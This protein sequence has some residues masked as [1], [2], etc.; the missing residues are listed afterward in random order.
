MKTEFTTE[1]FQQN[2]ERLRALFTGTAPIVLA[3]NGLM[4]R[5][6]DVTYPFR[7]DSSFWYLTGIDEPDLILVL[8]KNK[9]YLIVPDRDDTRKAF[10]GHVD[11]AKLS[12]ISGIENIVD[13]KDGWNQLSR[14]LKRVRHV[15]TLSP[16]PI[17]DDR[18]GIY[19]NPAR[20][21]LLTK[22]KA[23]ATEDLEL[24][25]LRTHL[26]RMRS[27]KQPIELEAIQAAIDLTADGLKKLYR[28]REKYD[29]EYEAEAELTAIFRKSGA[30]HAFQPIIAGG[31]N[32]CTLHRVANDSAINKNDLLLFDVGAEI[33]HYAADISR[34]V[35]IGEP[36]KRQKAI[37][38][39]VLEAQDF[40]ANE[41]RPGVLLKDYEVKVT[42]FMGEKLRELGLIKLIEKEEVRKYYPHAT[43]H[44]L[45]LDTHDVGDYERPLEQGMVLTVEPGIY[46][47][48]EGIGVRI[49]DDV[50][51]TEHGIKDLSANL[52]KFLLK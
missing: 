41:L 50:L 38:D 23:E 22:I 16:P 2:R 13:Y 40:A 9:E 43:S 4:Q 21:L 32:A 48:E 20:S 12:Q 25:D 17:F 45:G 39:A 47:P 6:G 29:Y 31:A 8:D 33:S 15:A 30:D 19:T 7:Q 49:E 26:R 52:P 42:Q 37:M 46:I 14:R 18:H 44:F 27:V 51:I 5:N 1:F 36:T 3:A 11:Y 35:A 24:L 10:D 34:T 28:K